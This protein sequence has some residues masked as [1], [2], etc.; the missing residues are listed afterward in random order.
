MESCGI[1]DGHQHDSIY[2]PRRY[3][4]GGA[5][6]QQKQTPPPRI[7]SCALDAPRSR[8]PVVAEAAPAALLARRAYTT[9]LADSRPTALL[10]VTTLT[11]VLAD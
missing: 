9:V 10:A 6:G 1:Q 5:A 11:T 8:L 2:R 7:P 3:A 4:I